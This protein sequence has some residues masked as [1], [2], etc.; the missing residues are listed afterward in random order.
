MPGLRIIK[1]R[2]IEFSLRRN[3]NQSCVNLLI[4]EIKIKR[5]L[6]IVKYKGKGRVTEVTGVDYAK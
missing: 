5:E 3:K 4:T 1:V 2:N 6:I